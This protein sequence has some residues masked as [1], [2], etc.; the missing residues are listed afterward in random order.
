MPSPREIAMR[1]ASLAS[2]WLIGW[3]LGL[4]AA[5]APLSHAAEVSVETLR[6]HAGEQKAPLIK[7]LRDVTQYE[8][9]S[10]EPDALDRSA[11]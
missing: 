7:S 9:G 2:A 3:T 4:P 11:T 8:S 1:H 10:R 6:G 5:M